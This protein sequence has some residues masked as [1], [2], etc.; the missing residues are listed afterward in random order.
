MRIM[1]N[2]TVKMTKYDVTGRNIVERDGLYA[3]TAA[4][5]LGTLYAYSHADAEQKARQ[6]WPGY[7][8]YTTWTECDIVALAL[9]A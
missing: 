8:D 2:A 3:Y 9:A 4:K 1:A 5:F 6:R 7:H